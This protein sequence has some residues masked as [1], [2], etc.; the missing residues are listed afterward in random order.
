MKVLISTHAGL[1]YDDAYDYREEVDEVIVSTNKIGDFGILE[2][3]IPTI[4][5]I[6]E[7]YLTL[8]RNKQTAYVVIT[9][10]ILEFSDNVLTVLC[11]EAYIGKTKERAKEIL[12]EIRQERLDSNRKQTVDY[13]LKE[14]EL[15]QSIKKTGAGQL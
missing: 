9:N 14:R 2:N 4:C 3:F 5:P 8:I 1:I 6:E 11:R 7:G 10:G 13:T 12:L 15:A